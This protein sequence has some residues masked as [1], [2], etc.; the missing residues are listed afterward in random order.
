MPK[1]MGSAVSSFWKGLEGRQVG[2]RLFLRECLHGLVG[3]GEDEPVEADHG[4]EEDAVVLGHPVRPRSGGR[5]A[6]WLSS[7]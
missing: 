6:S 2:I 7:A 5:W 3:V 4:R 1:E